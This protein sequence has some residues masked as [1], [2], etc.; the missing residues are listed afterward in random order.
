MK[1]TDNQQELFVVVD[2]DDHI[3][4]YR[5]RYDCHHDASLIHRGAVMF[6]FDEKGRV[7]LQK[8]S[9]TKDSDPGFWSMSA[10]GHVGKGES[11]EEAMGRELNEELGV[12]FQLTFIEKFIFKH[13][14]ETEMDALF[15]ANGKG[16]FK[17]NPLEV[18]DVKF[19]SR[20]VLRKKLTMPS[21]HMTKICREGLQKLGFL[22]LHGLMSV[23]SSNSFVGAKV[24]PKPRFDRGEGGFKD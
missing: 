15:T 3:L 19:F 16:P 1:T 13:P 11:Y 14:R 18:A 23:R 7:L 20:E 4:G 17:P 6:V 5:T 2:K 9:R 12:D 24:P 22:K 21:F 8:R 10:G